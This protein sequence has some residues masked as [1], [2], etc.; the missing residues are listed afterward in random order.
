MMSPNA[1]ASSS[2]ESA[3]IREL[4]RAV[5]RLE[6]ERRSLVGDLVVALDGWAASTD[7]ISDAGCIE[8]L[9]SRWGR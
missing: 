6:L 4:Q 3:V 2:P 5:R 1:G 9:R 8:T 7:D